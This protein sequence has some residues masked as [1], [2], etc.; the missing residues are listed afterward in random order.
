MKEGL[1]EGRE[2]E[3]EHEVIVNQLFRLLFI[4]FQNGIENDTSTR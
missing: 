4:V 1:G 2:G 3:A